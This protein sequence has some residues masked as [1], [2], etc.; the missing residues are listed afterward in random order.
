MGPSRGSLVIEKLKDIG[1]WFKSNTGV[2]DK[3]ESL[4]VSR[5][6]VA[7]SKIN[8]SAYSPT[9]AEQF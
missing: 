5:K 9:A 4:F 8:V 7:I 3:L 6:P 1:S 2:V